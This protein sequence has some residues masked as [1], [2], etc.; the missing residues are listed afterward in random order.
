MARDKIMDAI[1]TWNSA[2]QAV[3]GGFLTLQV[4]PDETVGTDL[5]VFFA[6][7]SLVVGFTADAQLT[8]Y[9]GFPG[10]AFA[11]RVIL[12]SKHQWAAAELE[13]VT[14]HEL[15]HALGFTDSH[16]TVTHVPAATGDDAPVSTAPVSTM[17]PASANLTIDSETLSVLR[18]A[19]GWTA[20]NPLRDRGTEHRPSLG[21]RIEAGDE[22]PKMVWKGIGEATIWESDLAGGQWSPQHDTHA[23]L[24]SHR[25]VLARVTDPAVGLIMAWREPDE[26]RLRWALSTTA[27]PDADGRPAWG[28]S[29]GPV[30][31]AATTDGP[32]L[33]NFAGMVWMAWTGRQGDPGLYWAVYDQA[34]DSWSAQQRVTAGP[35]GGPVAA[36][37]SPAL[38]GLQDSLVVFWRGAAP[39]DTIWVS[40]M[41]L[42]DASSN[43]WQVQQKIVSAPFSGPGVPV[44][45]AS[46]PSA[47][48][49]HDADIERLTGAPTETILLS[50]RGP[51]SDQSIYLSEIDRTEVGGATQ[52]MMS[53]QVNVPGRSTQT[54][55]A[56]AEA[57]GGTLMAWKGRDSDTA[58][59][60]SML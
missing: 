47:T 33:A 15:G 55:P 26:G 24:T 57:L 30:P 35:G 7:D 38:V 29:E 31:G 51:G 53:G 27:T 10:E 9:A 11:G 2:A 54:G 1:D 20:Q 22:T 48:L 40:S 23:G 41:K 36:T 46:G 28:P 12:N 3:A 6:D 18:A 60:W 32:A 34:A 52:F 56:V 49:R 59:Y 21:V 16:T 45:A 8:A 50:W 13:A 17:F 14:L 39:D 4:Q 5:A 25:P 42:A 37:D 19:Y 43:T 58:I 44:G